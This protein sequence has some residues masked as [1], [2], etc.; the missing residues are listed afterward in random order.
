MAELNVSRKT[1]SKLFTEMQNKKFII[2]EY[3]RPY[4]WDIEKCETLW[5]DIT[6]FYSTNRYDANEYFLGTIVS[7]KVADNKN[8]EIIDGQQRI[9]SFF[10]LLRAFYKKLEEMQEDA[11]VLGLRNQL[12]P[13]IWDVDPISQEIKN[14]K[15]VHIESLVATEEDNFRLSEILETG[16]TSDKNKDNYSLNYSFFKE[17]CDDFALEN[18]LQWKELCITILNRCIILPIECDTSETAL[19][20]FST[21]N[22]RGMP[23]SDS[24]I[25]K[26][27]LYKFSSS[28]EAKKEFTDKWKELTSI[29]KKA[30]ISVD[31]IFRYYTHTIR[32]QNNDRTKEVGLRR[33]YAG[34]GGSYTLLKSNDLMETLKQLALF[35]QYINT[36]NRDEELNYEFNIT[37]KRYIQVFTFYPN[38]FW[39]YITSVYFLKN[40]CNDGFDVEF[41]DFLKH[42]LSFMIVKFILNPSVNG[43]KNDIYNACIQIQNTGNIKFEEA[44]NK[45]LVYQNLS[46]NIS[47]K[48]QRALL[49]LHAYLNAEQVEAIPSNFEI[50]HIFPKKWQNTNYNGWDEVD[51]QLYLEKLGNKV[52]IEKKINILAG[53]GYF[54]KKKIKYYDSK[55]SDVLVLSSIKND[56]WL[57]ED[58]LNRENTFI[59]KLCEFFF[60]N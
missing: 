6:N 31:D 21:L 2:P 49:L 25:F 35:W 17:M 54:G 15:L 52:A 59:D 32:A 39:K 23:L 29:C 14:K 51:A 3:Q 22:D 48:L 19:T 16:V 26:A 50:E 28:I 55:I 18:P 12:A 7:Y 41:T 38:D 34:E 44:I 46:G 5:E 43:I 9:T 27:Q 10:L 45:D 30:S 47:I 36:D 33:F 58:I 56:D 53:N 4:K 8:I 42:V 11:Q 60:L 57:K 40:K 13:C 20:I 37:T 1:I 24:D